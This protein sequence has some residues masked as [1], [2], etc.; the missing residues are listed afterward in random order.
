MAQGDIRGTLR[1]LGGSILATSRATGSVAVVPGDLIFAVFGQQ[2]NLTITA[3][4]DNLGTGTYTATNAGTDAGT[5]TGR[6]FY[7]YVLTTATITAIN[8]TTTTSANDWACVAGVFEGRFSTLAL[9]RNPANNTVGTAS[10]ISVPA[11]GTVAQ[12]GELVIAWACAN[13][14]TNYT[15]TA[16]LANAAQT[17]SASNIKAYLGHHKSTAITNY[18]NQFTTSVAPAQIVKGANSFKFLLPYGALN[19]TLGT[20]IYTGAGSVF[21]QGTLFS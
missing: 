20:N 6:A 9:D 19:T 1:G 4:V 12:P 21:I 18:T 14:S 13:S 2:T 7:K 11:I 10:P 8:F 15:A 17:A 3:M 5:P 16:P